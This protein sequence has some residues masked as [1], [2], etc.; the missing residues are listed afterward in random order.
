MAALAAAV[1]NA[2]W[3]VGWVMPSTW[4]AAAAC[5]MAAGLL[6]I[7]SLLRMAIPLWTRLALVTAFAIAVLLREYG[8]IRFPLPENRR[9]V[10]ES[11]FRLGRFFKVDGDCRP[12]I[13]RHGGR[14]DALRGRAWPRSG[15]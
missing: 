10:P 11:V 5:V 2:L 7:G 15:P 13:H 12:G 4:L 6:V 9:L 1:A 8:L 14:A 3:P